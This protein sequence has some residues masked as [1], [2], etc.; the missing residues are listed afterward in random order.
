VIVLLLAALFVLAGIG[1][2]SE[3][4]GEEAAEPLPL[5]CEPGIPELPCAEGVEAGVPYPVTLQT[6]CEL[7]WAYFDGRYW[8][9][10]GPV[11]ESGGEAWFA[12]GV[13]TLASEDEAVFVADSGAEVRFQPAPDDYRP[14]PCA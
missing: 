8:V 5:V 12:D 11:S 13:M 14:P 7:E 4:E 2:G 6:H 10:S 3:E 1:L 9:P